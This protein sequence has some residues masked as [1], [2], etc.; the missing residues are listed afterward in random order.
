MEFLADVTHFTLENWYEA[1]FT[2]RIGPTK[3]GLLETLFIRG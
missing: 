2:R 3:K 1:G